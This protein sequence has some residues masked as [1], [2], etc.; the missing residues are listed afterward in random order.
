M[1][2][3]LK[4]IDLVKQ[5]AEPIARQWAQDVRKNPRTPHYHNIPEE[6]I[7]GQAVQFY[8]QLQELM[9]TKNAEELAKQYSSLYARRQFERGIP[10]HEALYAL[11][12]MRRKMWLFS[13]FQE[14]FVS[15]LE[16]QQAIDSISR[17]I[18]M[19]D[20]VVYMVTDEYQKLIQQNPGKKFGKNNS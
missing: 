18:L 12:L 6:E 7:V 3:S 2:S 20:Y 5:N 13:D 14:E 10:L 4:L 8:H 17:A 11:V 15:V 9:V 19:S 1:Q 16:H